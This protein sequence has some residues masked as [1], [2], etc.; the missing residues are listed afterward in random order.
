MNI[1][2]KLTCLIGLVIAPILGGH[3]EEEGMA[4]HNSTKEI[5]IDLDVENT[6]LAEAT[7]IYTTSVNGNSVTEEVTYSGTQEE[8]EAQLKAFENAS[9]AK[10]GTETAV[11]I[12][13]VEI[14]K[15]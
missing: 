10:K 9:V 3:T 13:K 1:L 8:V 6:D 4:Q 7:I 2:I 15:K 5:T 12:E 11:T 14:H